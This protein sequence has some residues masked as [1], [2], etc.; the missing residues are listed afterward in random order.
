MTEHEMGEALRAAA[1]CDNHSM[2]RL[3]EPAACASD[4]QIKK[5]KHI[6]L[7]FLQ[8]C[9]DDASALEMRELLE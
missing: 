3:I 4:A 6:I 9:P 1:E 5:M 8:E 2:S 7:V